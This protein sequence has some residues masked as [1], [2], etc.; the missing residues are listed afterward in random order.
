MSSNVTSHTITPPTPFKFQAVY[1]DMVINSLWFSSLIYELIAASMSTLIKQWIQRYTDEHYSAVREQSRVRQYRFLGLKDWLVPIAVDVPSFL[2]RIALTLFL[3]GMVSFPK[4]LDLTVYWAVTT[5][6][7]V[8]FILYAASII[9]PSI[10]QDCPYKLPE[11]FLFYLCMSLCKSFVH[12]V[13]TLHLL[14]PNRDASSNGAR[15]HHTHTS[16]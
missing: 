6:V 10:Y 5:P 12:Y 11:A 13:C 1:S 7:I 9:L 3:I 8:W 16:P 15:A 14:I 2:L 4:D